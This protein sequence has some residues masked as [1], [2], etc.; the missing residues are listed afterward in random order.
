MIAFVI[1]I[2]GAFFYFD[3]QSSVNKTNSTGTNGKLRLLPPNTTVIFCK[4]V[5]ISPTKGLVNISEYTVPSNATKLCIRVYCPSG[6]SFNIS[7]EI[8]TYPLNQNNITN[9]I[10][11]CTNSAD[12]GAGAGNYIHIHGIYMVSYNDTSGSGYP[13]IYIAYGTSDGKIAIQADNSKIRDQS[14]YYMNNIY[15]SQNYENS[16][17]SLIMQDLRR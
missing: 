7:S 17:L 13:L 12:S 15:Y 4:K 16:L 11:T 8:C 1:V 14:Q 3:G 10:G 2:A 6:H 9:S 5:H